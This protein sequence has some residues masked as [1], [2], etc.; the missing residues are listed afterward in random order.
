MRYA[1]EDG[2][3]ALLPFDMNRPATVVRDGDRGVSR[4]TFDALA[5]SVE[6]EITV[7]L[8]QAAVP[9][10]MRRHKLVVHAANLL[11]AAQLCRKMK[12]F[13]DQAASFFAEA[14]VKLRLFFGGVA[15]YA[16]NQSQA[17]VV[18]GE[19]VAIGDSTLAS[20]GLG[21]SVFASV[22]I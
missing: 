8:D 18:V 15:N 13:Q 20:S 6:T 11:I 7:R 19:T 2:V 22:K 5:D 17:E 10:S 1:T 9:Q 16:E 12:N 3:F 4:P 14:N 21:L